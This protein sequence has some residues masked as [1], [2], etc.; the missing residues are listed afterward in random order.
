MSKSKTFNQIRHLADKIVEISQPEKVILFGSWAWGNPGPDSDVD[1]CV[2]KKTADT[3]QEAVKIDQQISPRYFPLDII[4]YTPEY[5][6]QREALGDF[7][8]KNI[9]SKGQVLYTHAK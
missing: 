5:V 9:V 6:A 7:F 1:L 4:V 2:I 8:V 3:R